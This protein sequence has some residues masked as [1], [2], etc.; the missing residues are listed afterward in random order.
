MDTKRADTNVTGNATG[1]K[2]FHKVKKRK[3]LRVADPAPLEIARRAALIRA[4]WDDDTRIKRAGVMAEDG[5]QAELPEARVGT[6]TGTVIRKQV[7]EDGRV[8]G[9]A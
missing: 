5:Q 9:H 8:R 2:Q 4:E 1:G 6:L 7:D 3:N